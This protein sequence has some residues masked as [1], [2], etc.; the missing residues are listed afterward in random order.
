MGNSSDKP[1]VSPDEELV[2]E[3]V[4]YRVL[5]TLLDT[6]GESGIYSLED[7]VEEIVS[8]YDE[9]WMTATAVSWALEQLEQRGLVGKLEKRGKYR[10]YAEWPPEELQ[11]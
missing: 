5:F 8:E 7:L 11:Y 1:V 4:Q 9:E 2:D 3:V 6:S 10:Y